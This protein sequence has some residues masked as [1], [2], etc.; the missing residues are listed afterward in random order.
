MM[1][2]ELHWVDGPW[3]GRLALAARPR[4]GEWLHDELANWQRAGVNT[5]LSL[6]QPEEEADLDLTHEER[7]A[8]E[9][10]MVF[11]SF[12]I[13]DRQVPDSETKL[14]KLLEKVDHDL[15]SGGNVVLHCRQGIGRTGLVAACLLITKG[16]ETKVALTRLS[17][18]RGAPVPETAEQR[19]W[20]DH[21]ANTFANLK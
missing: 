8:T 13:H 19:R 21:Y 10:G 9:R 1:S 15:A 2:T 18:A 7:E 3:P 11:R 14:A 17:S 5:V 16:L 12:P 6:L 20:I 4:G